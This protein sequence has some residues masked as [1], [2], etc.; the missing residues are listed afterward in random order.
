MRTPATP[1]GGLGQNKRGTRL[2]KRNLSSIPRQSREFVPAEKKDFN[3]W[4]KR[5]KNNVAAKKSRERRRLQDMELEKRVV[6]LMG[7]NE[8][9]RAELLTLRYRLGLTGV[10][11]QSQ[12]LRRGDLANL[13]PDLRTLR[14]APTLN[15][16][17]GGAPL[18]ELGYRGAALPAFVAR[19]GPSREDALCPVPVFRQPFSKDGPICP[20][21][22]L[23]CVKCNV[24]SSASSHLSK[25]Q[26]RQLLSSVL[27]SAVTFNGLQI[28]AAQR[29]CPRRLGFKM[30]EDGESGQVQHRQSCLNIAS[31]Q[32]GLVEIFVDPHKT[33][34]AAD[35][36]HHCSAL[37]SEPQLSP[38]VDRLLRRRFLFPWGLPNDT[39]SETG[40][41]TYLP[42]NKSN[43]QKP[44]V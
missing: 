28:S 24:E 38:N 11:P 34:F 42:I 36:Y 44:D 22:K 20:R 14:R 4:T 37:N 29:G 31:S 41:S 7:D 27:G 18:F 23:H 17:S 43:A 21:E 40:F 33:Y 39:L 10:P 32:G 25:P 26:D 8:R 6:A 15:V 12:T 5:G 3:Y 16:P 35:L 1:S 9:L 19:P 2:Q 30:S 13:L